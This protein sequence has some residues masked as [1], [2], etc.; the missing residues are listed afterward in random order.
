M[1]TCESRRSTVGLICIFPGFLPSLL[2]TTALR[3]ASRSNLTRVSPTQRARYL[4]EACRTQLNGESQSLTCSMSEVC[5]HPCLTEKHLSTTYG[6]SGFNS[7]LEIHI[8]SISCGRNRTQLQ[9]YTVYS[10]C[11]SD[12]VVTPPAQ[13][14]QVNTA[15]A[16]TYQ[17]V[18][19]LKLDTYSSDGEQAN[20]L[21]PQLGV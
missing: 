17:S 3:G 20:R 18:L 9:S 19:G 10:V 15:Q 13:E 21:D 1:R 4:L 7:L 12:A 11:L 14:S 8:L 5:T 2:F 6:K 16:V